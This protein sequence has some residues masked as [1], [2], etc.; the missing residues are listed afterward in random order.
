MNNTTK[1][2]DLKLTK[3]FNSNLT[4]EQVIKEVLK[5]TT[6]LAYFFVF[7]ANSIDNEKTK[8]FEKNKVQIKKIILNI[9]SKQKLSFDK[10]YNLILIYTEDDFK[11]LDS[12]FKKS[13][14]TK[15]N[16][17]NIKLLKLL[18][19]MEVDRNNLE[20]YLKGLDELIN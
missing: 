14:E 18:I 15:I 20:D 10:F 5:E 7:S 13:I 2:R 17:K 6:D 4:V 1:E 11:N 16:D 19:D 9:I 3:L 12:F 8:Y